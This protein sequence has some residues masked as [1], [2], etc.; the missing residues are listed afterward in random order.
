VSSALACLGLA[1]SDDD[2]FTVLLKHALT[3]IREIGTFGGVY[4]G[5]WQ[6]DSGA[7]LTLGLHDGQVADLTF[8]YAGTSGG[9]LADCR[10]IYQSIAWAQ[11]TDE[12]GQQVTAMAFEAEQYRQLAAGSH[13][14][15]GPARIT[16]L[17]LDVTVYP[18]PEAFAASP[19]SQVHLAAGIAS[20]PPPDWGGPWP[21]RL[22]AESFTSYAGIADRPHLQSRAWLSG[23]VLGAT[24]RVSG[25]T[26]QAFTV[27]AV[28]TA[29]FEAS[30]CLA[31]SDHPELP[32]PGSII[33]GT[34]I[35]SAAVDTPILNGEPA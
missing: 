4:V 12:A 35:L 17:G 7:V 34:V 13:W 15:S 28:R 14:V 9:L 18:D 11:V 27:A 23:T 32:A 16:A 5:R 22:A 19:A 33:A 1:V 30:L 24:R 2:E 31:A 10:L 21:P 20:P 6:D 25:L 26:G 3:G 8:S 29:G